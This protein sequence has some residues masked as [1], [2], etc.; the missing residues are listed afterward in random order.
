MRRRTVH[1]IAFGAVTAS[2]ALTIG[3]RL[4]LVGAVCMGL[5]LILAL[6]SLIPALATFRLASV[7]SRD[8]V[9]RGE[10]I[11]LT[12]FFSFSGLLPIGSAA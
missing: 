4:L 9:R 8:R 6:L 11:R 7:Q 2:V 3:S 12:V 1:F 5:I 10:E